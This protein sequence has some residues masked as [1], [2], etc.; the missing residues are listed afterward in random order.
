MRI[1]YWHPNVQISPNFPILY[2][3]PW[4]SSQ[5]FSVSTE[6]CKSLCTSGFVDDVVFTQCNEWVRIKDDAYVSSLCQVAA[7]G[8]KSAVCDCIL[9]LL[10]MNVI[11]VPCNPKRMQ[12]YLLYRP[13]FISASSSSSCFLLHFTA[14]IYAPPLNPTGGLLSHRSPVFFLSCLPII[15]RSTPLDTYDFLL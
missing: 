8:A 2:R 9:S 13:R 15:T 6:Q 1:R 3:W 12:I 4:L 7:P 14:Q 10:Q 11:R 5:P